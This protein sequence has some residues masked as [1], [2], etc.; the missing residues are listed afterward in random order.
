[1]PKGRMTVFRLPEDVWRALAEQRRAVKRIN[2]T[3]VCV[4]ALRVVLGKPT[5][6]EDRIATLEDK[7]KQLEDDIRAHTSSIIRLNRL[8]RRE[9]PLE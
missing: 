3:E 9:R 2:V 8:E 6:T 4:A 1:M 7:V 5:I